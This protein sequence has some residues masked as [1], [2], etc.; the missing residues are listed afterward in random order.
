MLPVSS[1][2]LKSAFRMSAVLLRP[3]GMRPG[4]ARV[5]QVSHFQVDPCLDLE[6][7]ENEIQGVCPGVRWD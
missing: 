5:S 7:A 6:A 4:G 3:L 1:Q 2:G